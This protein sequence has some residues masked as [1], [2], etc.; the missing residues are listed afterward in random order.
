VLASIIFELVPPVNGL[1]VDFGTFALNECT[2]VEPFVNPLNYAEA[3]DFGAVVVNSDHIY[4]QS[5][6]YRSIT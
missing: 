5:V 2:G 4:S 1:A 6:Y 3:S